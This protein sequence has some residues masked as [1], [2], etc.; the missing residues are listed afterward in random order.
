[1]DRI[2]FCR[3][4]FGALAAQVFFKRKGKES[5]ARDSQILCRFLGF[6]IEPIRNRNRRFH[7]VQYNRGIKSESTALERASTYDKKNAR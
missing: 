3:D 4:T 7:E 2:Q 5:A 6:A 1:M